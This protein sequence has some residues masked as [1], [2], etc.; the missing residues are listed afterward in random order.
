M[1]IRQDFSLKNLFNFPPGYIS[2]CIC[3]AGK[4]IGYAHGLS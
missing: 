2:L 4:K 1:N 3:M